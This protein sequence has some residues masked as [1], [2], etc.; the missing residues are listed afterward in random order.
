MF[1]IIPAKS[2]SEIE[3]IALLAGQIWTEHFTAIIGQSQV[4]YMLEKFQSNKAISEQVAQGYEYYLVGS[5]G[6][7]VGY[8]A[9]VKE[10]DRLMISKLYALSSARG[11]GIGKK[12]LEFIESKCKSEGINTIWLTVNKHNENVISWYQRR[13]FST[14]DS[15]KADI[16]EGFFMDDYIM[17]KSIYK[18]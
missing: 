7:F 9:L 13:G 1:E 5:P 11:I 18:I 17:E 4:E 15:V 6:K 3:Q 8:T 16:G 12:I 14:V 10:A 2:N